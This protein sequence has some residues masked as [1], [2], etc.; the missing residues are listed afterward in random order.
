MQ[1]NLKEVKRQ[2]MKDAKN[3]N[4]RKH[5]TNFKRQLGKKICL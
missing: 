4:D 1:I 2:K 3:D 5:K